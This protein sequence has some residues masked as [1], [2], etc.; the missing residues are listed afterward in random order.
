MSIFKGF[1]NGKFE[2]G[3]W[4]KRDGDCRLTIEESIDIAIQVAGGL[5]AAHEKG[6]IHRDIKP[7]NIIITKRGE[8]KIVDFGLAKLAGQQITKSI[9]T[10]GTVAYMSPE[11]IRGLDIDHRADI[12]SLGVVL[13]EMLTGELPFKG[14]HELPL[15]Y[16]IVNETPKPLASFKMDVPESL[17]QIL[18]KLLNKVPDQRY[19]NIDNLLFDLQN[20]QIDTPQKCSKKFAVNKDFYGNQAFFDLTCIIHKLCNGSKF[21]V[22]SSWLCSRLLVRTRFEF[23]G[24]PARIIGLISRAVYP[25]KTPRFLRIGRISPMLLKERLSY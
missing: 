10:L 18:D 13:Y 16:T 9:T 25:Q 4:L 20:L 14:E 22:K 24:V 15:M 5:A 12:W 17:Q 8:V 6:I 3:A 23:L 21:D 11:Y 19:Q 7:A 1:E 2:Y